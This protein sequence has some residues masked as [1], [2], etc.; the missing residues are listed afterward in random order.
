V[1]HPAKAD[2]RLR[3]AVPGQTSETVRPKRVVSR[4]AVDCSRSRGPEVAAAAASRA[5][6]PSTNGSPAGP[7][8]AVPSRRALTSPGLI[9]GWAERISAAAPLTIAA[10]NEVPDPAKPAVPTTDPGC[11]R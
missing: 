6:W 7:G 2:G 5:P 11:W 3:G 10:L 8:L 1:L 9:P 4:P